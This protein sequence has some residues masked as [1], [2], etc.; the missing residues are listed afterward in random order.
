MTPPRHGAKPFDGRKSFNGRKSFGPK[1]LAAFTSG[2]IGETLAARGIGEASLVASWPAI[3]GEAIARY[4]RPLQL[5]WPPSVAKRDPETA[6]SATLVL[7]IDGAFALE[8]QHNAAI[9]TE[10]VNA[11]LGWRCVGRIV[12]R[13]GPLPPLKERRAPP[14]PP[15][16]EAEADA[17]E[18]AAAIGADDLR[19]AVARLGALAIDR[20]AR[21][22]A[23]A[24]TAARRL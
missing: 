22:A 4:A 21:I 9:I 14:A 18:A 7:S 5:Q 8:A 6:V 17:R 24:R 15:S 20:D 13:Q 23:A 12:F 11:H 10:R 2:I 3:V 16:A 19:D 1:P